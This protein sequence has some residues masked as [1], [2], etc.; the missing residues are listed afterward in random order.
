MIPVYLASPYSHPDPAVRE[1][2][3][4]A[5]CRAAAALVS[6]GYAV[7]CPIAHSHPIE[8]AMAEMGLEN[9]SGD[10]WVDL[11]LTFAAVC[12][13]LFVLKLEDWQVSMGVI[14][15]CDYFATRR[16]YPEFIE[17]EEIR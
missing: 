10:A 9:L 14:R 5:V 15:E 2:R 16:I 7:F 13:K 3:F 11:D 4:R 12:Q 1:R 8:M 17:E 6:Q